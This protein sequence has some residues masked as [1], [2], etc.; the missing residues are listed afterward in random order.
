ML[1]LLCQLPDLVGILGT[2][3]KK[4]S[5]TFYKAMAIPEFMQIFIGEER[6]EEEQGQFKDAQAPEDP[7]L[8]KRWKIKVLLSQLLQKSRSTQNVLRNFTKCSK[9]TSLVPEL[10]KVTYDLMW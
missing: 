1:V 5:Q 8:E 4:V 7:L 9:K 2:V 10:K 3:A 6:E